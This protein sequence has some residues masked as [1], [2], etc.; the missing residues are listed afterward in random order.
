M[1]SG[2]RLSALRSLSSICEWIGNPNGLEDEQMQNGVKM[3]IPPEISL[4]ALR[5]ATLRLT[6]SLWRVAQKNHPSPR[7]ID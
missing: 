4:R 7:I 5:L 6:G 3:S 2:F 1:T